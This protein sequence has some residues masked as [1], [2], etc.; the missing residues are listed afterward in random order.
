MAKPLLPD[1]LWNRIEPLLPAPKPRRFRYPGRKPVDDRKVLTGIL[2]VLKTGIRWEDLPQEM[3]CGSGMTCW[4]RLR[5]WHEAGVWQALHELL[6][7]ELNS[8]DQIDWSRAAV[9]SSSV[10]A[11]GGGEK[12]GPN[13]TDRAKPGSKHHV[14][15]DGGGIPLATILTGANAADVSQL[16]PLV[17]AIPP[18]KG[19]PGHPRSRPDRVYADRAYD[20]E[21]HRDRVRGR[22]IDPQIARRHTG[23]G[24]GLGRYRWV[25]ERTFSW[26]HRPRKLRLRTDWRADMQE[27]LMSLC[28]SLICW[29][30]LTSSLS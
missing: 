18:V 20:S 15:T 9:D 5:D 6:L 27:A 14:I 22:G 26:F 29:S 25:V 4:R 28:C 1:G 8:A 10:R 17:D 3:G 7:A 23:H 30:V 13:P 21:P 12:T 11:L 2:F 19:K 24:S 16:E